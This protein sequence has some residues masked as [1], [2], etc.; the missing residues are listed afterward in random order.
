MTH[1]DETNGGAQTGDP[2]ELLGMD[3]AAALL[4]VPVEQV[5]SMVEQGMLTQVEDADGPCFRRAELIAARE[6]GG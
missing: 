1:H 4:G 2:A 5:R 6:A 3:A